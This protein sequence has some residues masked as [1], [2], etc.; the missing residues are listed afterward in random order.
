MHNHRE[1]RMLNPCIVA[2]GAVPLRAEKPLTLHYR[3]ATFDE[4]APLRRR[5]EPAREWKGK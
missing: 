2:L 1:V 3:V 4:A 5:D